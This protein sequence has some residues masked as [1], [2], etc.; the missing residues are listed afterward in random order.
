MEKSTRFS[1]RLAGFAPDA[2][3][4][5]SMIPFA[6]RLCPQMDIVPTCNPSSRWLS[7]AILKPTPERIKRDEGDI[8]RTMEGN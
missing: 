1:R 3:I 6:Y 2:H 8:D 7:V 5:R 4:E